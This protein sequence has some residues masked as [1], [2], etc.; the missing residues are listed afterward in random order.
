MVQMVPI[1]LSSVIPH[2]CNTATPYVSWNLRN[3]AGVQ[4]AP[5]MMVRLMLENDWPVSST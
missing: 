3:M 4:A 1:G 2:A 5:P